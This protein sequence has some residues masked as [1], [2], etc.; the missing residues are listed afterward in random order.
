MQQHRKLDWASISVLI[1][2]ICAVA[3]GLWTLHGELVRINDSMNALD[4]RIDLQTGVIRGRIAKVETAVKILA[5]TQERAEVQAL[6]KDALA[7][8]SSG[9]SEPK[10]SMPIAS[11]VAPASKKDRQSEARAEKRPKHE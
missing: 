6:V 1:T 5:D 11:S 8:A 9:L 3:A 7:A 2:I 4:K 10:A